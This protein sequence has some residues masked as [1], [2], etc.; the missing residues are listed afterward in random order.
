M[1]SEGHVKILDFGLA[2]L[3]HAESEPGLELPRVNRR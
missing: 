3:T 2:K 1:T